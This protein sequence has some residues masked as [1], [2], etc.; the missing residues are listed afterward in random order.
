MMWGDPCLSTHVVTAFT[1]PW[2]M[3]GQMDGWTFE[4][5]L[6]GHELDDFLVFHNKTHHRTV[7]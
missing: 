4:L 2:W 7:S 6:S 3:D 5:T 1:S